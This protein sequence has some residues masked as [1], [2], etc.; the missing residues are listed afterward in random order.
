M[1][2]IRENQLYFRIYRAQFQGLVQYIGL[3]IALFRF[4][5]LRLS[6]LQFISHAEGGI[7]GKAKNT[8]TPEEVE[9]REKKHLKPDF[10]DN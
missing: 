1:N 4:K 9:K 8:L 2:L 10:M 6:L 7:R 3:A 5:R